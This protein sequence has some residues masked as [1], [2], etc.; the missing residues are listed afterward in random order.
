MGC[1]ES[2]PV[3]QAEL[4][5]LGWHNVNLGACEPCPANHAGFHERADHTHYI[6]EESDLNQESEAHRKKHEKTQKAAKHE[7]RQTSAQRISEYPSERSSSKIKQKPSVIVAWQE[8]E[9]ALLESSVITVARGRDVHQPSYR[10]LSDCSDEGEF[11]SELARIFWN[12]VAIMVRSRDAV[13]CCHKYKELHDSDGARSAARQPSSKQRIRD[14]S[15]RGMGSAMSAG[16]VGDNASLASS[17]QR[18]SRKQSSSA[19]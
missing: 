9:I 5:S 7:K 6:I 8:R 11:Q 19:S 12:R 1:A 14:N 18:H 3:C 17:A 13:Q 10:E 16:I 15:T 2:S 4:K